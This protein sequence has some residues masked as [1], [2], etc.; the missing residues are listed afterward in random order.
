VKTKGF[1]L[2]ELLILIAILGVLAGIA[3]PGFSVLLPDY[4]LRSAA[5]DLQSNMQLAKIGAIKANSNWAIVFDPGV[6]PGRY[7]LCS[8]PGGNGTWE[9]PGSD[10]TVEKI[11]DLARYESGVDYGHGNA[12]SPIGATF[13]NEIT[14]GNDVL[15]FRPRA[16]A[17]DGYVYL[18]NSKN[19]NAYG[20][21]TRISGVVLLRKWNGAA[22]E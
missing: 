5:R 14:Y 11:I 7:Y 12:G 16:T 9:G 1:S 8:D 18:Q 22:W 17:D 6:T 15:V 4:R 20:V 19:T 10:D 21:G 2:I 3:V 13:D